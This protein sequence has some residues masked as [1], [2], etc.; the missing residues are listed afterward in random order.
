MEKLAP[1]SQSRLW[2]RLQKGWEAPQASVLGRSG[3]TPRF[4]HWARTLSRNLPT[5]CRAKH[6]PVVE[7]RPGLD[8]SESLALSYS[9]TPLN[10]ER[11][12]EDQ[13]ATS[14]PYTL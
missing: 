9:A 7:T 6:I 10:N 11:T 14:N 12:G 4:H 13:A 2:R 3:E 5:I 1:A 8:V